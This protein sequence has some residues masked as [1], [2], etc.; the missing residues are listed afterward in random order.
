VVLLA[1]D[2][3]ASGVAVWLTFRAGALHEPPGRSGLAHLVE[4]VLFAGPTPDAA[5][6]ELLEARRARHVN[7]TTG[8][9]ALSFEVVVP[10]EELPLALWVA[11]DRLAS[12]LPRVD[13]DWVARNRKVV[14]QERALRDVDAPYGLVREHLFRRL[15]QAPHP[16]HGGVIGVPG[17]LAAATAGDVRRFAGEL[18]VPAN[19]VLAV[20]GRFDPAVARRLAEDGLGR[21]PPGQR[22]R[23]P[24]TPAPPPELVDAREEPLARRPAV[25]LAWRLPQ[26]WH[27]DAVALQLGAQLLTFLVDGAWGMDV[28]AH[29]AEYAGESLFTMELSVPYEETMRAVHDDADGLLRMLTHREMPA[30][31]LAAANLALDR[32]AMFE[33]DTL[34][35]RARTLTRIELIDGGRAS[36][37]DHLAWHWELEGGVLRDTARTWLTKNPRVVIH[38]RPRRPFRARSERE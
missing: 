11:A 6:G 10:A 13:D 12:W 16:L 38:A 15:Y 28:S 30:D 35:G 34:E 18:L 31:F 19:G 33:L 8:F 36:V 22:A 37:G 25:T 23:P 7:A 1:P 29:L 27:G 14:E 2:A 5:Y 17:E 32:A 4:H 9:D 24:A 21:L 26:L 20:V 3:S